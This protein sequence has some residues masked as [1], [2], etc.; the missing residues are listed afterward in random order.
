DHSYADP[1]NWW[2]ST[3]EKPPAYSPE[4]D[5]GL[6]PII[7]EKLDEIAPQLRKLSLNIHG[8]PSLMLTSLHSFAHDALTSF[9]SS[10]GFTVTKNYL[11]LS[12][13]FRAEFTRGKGGRV[14]GINSEYDALKG[15]GHAC[16]HNLIAVSG[17]GV[18]IA[19]KAALEACDIPGTVVLLGT[20]AE[21]GG[22]GKIILLKRGGYKGMDLCI[23]CHPSAGPANSANVG[24]TI[25]MQDIEVEYMGQ[26]AHAGAAPWEGTNAL[27]AAFLAYSSISVLRQ[28]MRPDHRVHGIIEGNQDWLPNGRYFSSC[29]AVI[30]D[31]AKMRWM[32]R[33]PRSSDLTAFVERVKNCFQAAA[34]ATSC[35][36]KLKLG[37]PYYDLNQNQVLGK[38]FS[39]VVMRR[40]DITTYTMA[41]SASTDF[42]NVSYV[43]PALHPGYAIPTEPLQGNHTIGFTK[44]A[45]SQ[46]AHEATML[47]TKGLAHTGFRALRDDE[48]YKQAS[49]PLAW[50]MPR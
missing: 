3:D 48:F 5:S 21:E 49:G 6:L 18:A 4:R 19:V 17:C 26:N 40:Y 9:M 44:A 41:G 33:A 7:D 46:E 28:Q 25:A 32:V 24:T 8:T 15:I 27:D 22:G 14:L 30:P 20:P 29:P 10:H 50:I 31:Y 23:M 1:S 38:E 2:L 43:L 34:L 47:I 36:I 12:T 35:E 39:E 13:A 16:G 45:A 11:G 42:G 37:S